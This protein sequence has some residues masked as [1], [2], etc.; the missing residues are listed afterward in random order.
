MHSSKNKTANKMK[1]AT[2]AVLI[3]PLIKL[4]KCGKFARYKNNSLLLA[5]A[6][7]ER[8]SMT[9]IS[10]APSIPAV[11]MIGVRDRLAMY[12]AAALKELIN[13]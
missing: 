5:F 6:E 11:A 10:N 8:Y 9:I 3:A 12:N 1:Y 2:C 7:P 4:V 13:I